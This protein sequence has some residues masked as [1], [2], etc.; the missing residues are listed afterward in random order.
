MTTSWKAAIGRYRHTAAL[1]DGRIASELLRLDVADFP[2]ITRAFAPMVRE[3]RF[4][5]S[6]MAI[7]TYLQAETHGKALDLLPVVLSARLQE[8]SLLCRAD[9][10]IRGPADLAG[11]RIGVRAYSQ[12][13]GLW[14]RGILQ[15][16][17]GVAADAMRWTTFEDPH[18]AEAGDP[19]WAERAP[20][21]AEIGAM[22]RDGL[23]DAA[24]FGSDAPPMEWARPVFPDVA[25]AGRAFVERHGFVPVNHLMV[26]RRDRAEPALV[27]ELLRMLAAS[28]AQASS[29][30]PRGWDALAAPLALARRYAAEQGL[31]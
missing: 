11:K 31:I 7:A 16:F 8:G 5:V 14:L 29:G 24:I 21:G 9:S 1:L 12:T 10:A 2:N 28:D 19:P 3:L 13:T 18:V 23:L 17:H 30:L 20:A 4:D 27:E 6:E 25:A 26:V 22:L 15:E